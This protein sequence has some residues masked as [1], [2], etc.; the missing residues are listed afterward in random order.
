MEDN[1]KRVAFGVAALAGAYLVYRTIK[2]SD[3]DSKDTQTPNIEKPQN[4][5]VFIGTYTEKLGH[6]LGDKLGEGIY[7]F[8]LNEDGSLSEQ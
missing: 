8:K 5:F 3:E 7:I 6:I 1:W 2:S 4:K